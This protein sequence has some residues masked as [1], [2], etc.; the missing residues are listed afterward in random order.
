MKTSASALH[1][2]PMNLWYAGILVAD[3]A[4]MAWLRAGPAVLGAADAADAADHRVR[5]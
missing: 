3:V 5:H 1:A 4:G 2:V